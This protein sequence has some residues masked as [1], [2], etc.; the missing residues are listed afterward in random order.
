MARLSYTP[1]ERGNRLRSSEKRCHYRLLDPFSSF[2]QVLLVMSAGRFLSSPH[3]EH[4]GR[5]RRSTGWSRRNSRTWFPL[6]RPW[7]RSF[8]FQE[9]G[10]EAVGNHHLVRLPRLDGP[11]GFARG[12]GSWSSTARGSHAAR[13]S[14]D[15]PGH[16]DGSG[17][18]MPA[19]S[20]GSTTP[21]AFDRTEHTPLIA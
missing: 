15:A 16:R 6:I 7:I 20:V 12:A 13:C 8:H 18:P 1:Q 3:F 10:F 4:R 11:S 14:L 21:M 19:S 2:D 5:R 9:L 17:S